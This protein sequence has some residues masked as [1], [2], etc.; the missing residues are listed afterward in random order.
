MRAG[1]VRIF[2]STLEDLAA[3]AVTANG[4]KIVR[5]SGNRLGAVSAAGDS[6]TAH[7]P[8]EVSVDGN[9]FRALPADLQLLKTDA[10]ATAFRDNAVTDVDLGPFLFGV[11]PAV[12]VSGNRFECDCDPRRV[13]VLK[14]NQVFP[15]LLPEADNGRFDALLAD[16]Y[17]RK[18]AALTLAGYRDQLIK[19]IA[20]EGTNVTAAVITPR[21][22]PLKDGGDAVNAAMSY[23][24][25]VVVVSLLHFAVLSG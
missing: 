3:G 20:C 25:L 2:N 15:G 22:P 11:G 16:N 14:L 7:G 21:A 12:R 1:A 19:E 5:L 23:A 9:Q 10:P 17:C 18:P 24:L 6:V 8:A 4:S 13:S